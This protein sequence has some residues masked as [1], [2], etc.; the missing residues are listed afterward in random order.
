[1]ENL[2]MEMMEFLIEMSVVA[3]F[4]T[5]VTVLV[6]II[7]LRATGL[8][9]RKAFLI[10]VPVVVA[11]AIGAAGPTDHADWRQW[12]YYALPPIALGLPLVIM[13]FR[14][15]L[16]ASKSKAPAQPWTEEE[17]REF[18]EAVVE[19]LNRNVLEEAKKN[20]RPPAK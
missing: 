12:A 9:A 2:L 1:M 10:G 14:D 17:V 5:L 15:R 8:Y 7:V 4:T 3:A 19:N 6:S 11:I 13:A 18:G 16:Q 20:P